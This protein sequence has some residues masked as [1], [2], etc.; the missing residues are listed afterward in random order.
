MS[1]EKPDQ[2][3]KNLSLWAAVCKTSPSYTRHVNQRGGF[4]A[5]DP[6]YQAQK[7]TEVFGMYGVGWGLRNVLIDYGL[8][9][10]TGMVVMKGEFFYRYDSQEGSFPVHNA[11]KT[12]SGFGDK[13]RADEDFAKKL[14]TNILSKALSRLGFSADVFL[15]L[16]DDTGYVETAKTREAIERADNAEEAQ[17]DE[18][19]KFIEWCEREIQTYSMIPNRAALKSV[20]DGHS[21]KIERQCQAVGLNSK[22]YLNRFHEEY[23]KRDAEL[24]EKLKIRKQETGK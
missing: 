11:I 21:R 15:G 5:I 23:E 14:E 7:A 9:E 3:K 12:C 24:V 13:S 19:A 16:F 20:L 1:T 4:T 18:Q 6:T 2:G 22:A 8:H 10:S 17:R